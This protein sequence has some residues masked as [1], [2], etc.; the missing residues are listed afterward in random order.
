VVDAILRVLPGGRVGIR[1]APT[2]PAN[3][4]SDSTPQATFGTLVDELSK[5]KLAYIHVIEGAT[6]GARDVLPFDFMALR[7]AFSG[8]YIA[9]NGYTRDLAIEAIASGRADMI[10]F[11]RPFIANPDLVE[12]LRIGAPLNEPNR[13]TFYGGGAEGYT[14]YPTLTAA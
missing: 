12:R 13:A 8:A 5:R 14:D 3:D 6:Q 11:G 4:I 10:A 9:N 1:I 2:S 7:R